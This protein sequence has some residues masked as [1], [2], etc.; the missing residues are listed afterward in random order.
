MTV[1]C[2]NADPPTKPSTA[3]QDA[4]ST[5][6]TAVNPTN[7]AAGYPV[8]PDASVATVRPAGTNRAVSSTVPPRR[9]SRRAARS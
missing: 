8:A 3:D 4:E 7:R 6:P 9:S 2:A 1:S 5:E